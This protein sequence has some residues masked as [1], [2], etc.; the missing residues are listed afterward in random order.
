M[1]GDGGMRP[2]RCGLQPRG[3][4]PR[5]DGGRAVSMPGEWVACVARI[6]EAMDARG[7]DAARLSVATGIP[8]STIGTWLRCEAV[9]SADRL[10][11]VCSALGASADWVLGLRGAR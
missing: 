5:V 6:R 8:A 10:A 7:I 11:S 2:T 1:V 4:A 3:R 9:P